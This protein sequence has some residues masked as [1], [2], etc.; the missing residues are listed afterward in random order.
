MDGEEIIKGFFNYGF[1]SAISIYLLVRLEG[2]LERLRKQ[3]ELNT[4]ILARSTGLDIEEEKRRL[5][6]GR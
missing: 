6:D 4:I 3:I 2:V 5:A 1:P